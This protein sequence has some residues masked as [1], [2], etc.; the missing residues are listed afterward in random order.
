MEGGRE[1]TREK[2]R[3]MGLAGLVKNI[4]LLMRNVFE[5]RGSPIYEWVRGVSVAVKG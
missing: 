1:E 4:I 5:T 3:A 2:I